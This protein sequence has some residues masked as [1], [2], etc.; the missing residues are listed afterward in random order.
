MNLSNFTNKRSRFFSSL[1]S[2]GELNITGPDLSENITL[3][4]KDIKSFL[5]YCSSMLVREPIVVD[6]I[7]LKP[8][9]NSIANEIVDFNTFLSSTMLNSKLS[10]YFQATTFANKESL[11]FKDKGQLGEEN[12]YKPFGSNVAKSIDSMMTASLDEIRA[13]S[14][15]YF[16]FKNFRGTAVFNRA[17]IHNKGYTVYLS[18]KGLYLTIIAAKYDTKTGISS[19]TAVLYIGD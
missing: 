19:Y 3:Q 8:L 10:F 9:A 14:D 16:R 1:E 15:K 6:T 17:Y 7:D 5:G 2:V 4:L 11:D 18:D 13:I 12:T